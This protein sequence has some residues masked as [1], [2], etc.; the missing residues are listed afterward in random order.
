MAPTLAVLLLGSAAAAP[1][2]LNW[3]STPAHDGE[4]VIASGGG[5]TNASVVTL[6]GSDGT[7][8]TAEPLN[9]HSSGIGFKLPAG[10]VGGMSLYDVSVDGSSPPII[11]NRPDG[12]GIMKVLMITKKIDWDPILWE[13]AHARKDKFL[14]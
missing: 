4:T 13:M 9:V 12:R 1:P 6:T 14:T 8:H 11:V 2:T 7:K 5:F 10:T 3:V